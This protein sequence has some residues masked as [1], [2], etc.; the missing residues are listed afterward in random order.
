MHVL[1]QEGDESLMRSPNIYPKC[2]RKDPNVATCED[3][4]SS[5]PTTMFAS[6]ESKTQASQSHG[7]YMEVCPFGQHHMLET[8]WPWMDIL[9][10]W[11]TV[12]YEDGE[13]PSDD[14]DT[15]EEHMPPS[16]YESK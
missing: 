8:R 11:L 10:L 3:I 12:I 15:D 1:H 2:Q 6:S 4:W 14:N 9:L 16:E 7:S 5:L 13:S